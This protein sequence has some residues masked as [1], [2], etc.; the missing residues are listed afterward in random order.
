MSGGWG[1]AFGWTLAFLF[2][3]SLPVSRAPADSE[4]DMAPR[5]IAQN[6]AEASPAEPPAEGGDQA[7]KPEPPPGPPTPEVY[8]QLLLERQQLMIS[9]HQHMLKILEAHHNDPLSARKDLEIHFAE[10][11]ERLAYLFKKHNVSPEEY[12]RSCRG[13]QELEKRS[14]YLDDHP[15][16]RDELARNSRQLR[17]LERKVW[18]IMQALWTGKPGSG[19]PTRRNR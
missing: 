4:K 13:A 18:A 1:K 16:I 6:Q 9:S 7:E 10:R 17:E 8:Y 3:L 15:E 11:E 12:Y 14:Q 19:Q 2:A 5:F